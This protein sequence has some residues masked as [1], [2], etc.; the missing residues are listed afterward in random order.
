[1]QYKNTITNIKFEEL[2]NT[3]DYDATAK[4]LLLVRPWILPQA[5]A[6]IAEHWTPKKVGELYS[7]KATLQDISDPWSR[8]LWTMLT[9]VK[10]SLLV[11]K[12]ASLD[13]APYCGLVPLILAA[14]KKYHNIR[15]SEWN[16]SELKY[17]VDKH[18][19]DAMLCE[20]PKL[21]T[22]ELVQY[23]EIG[24]TLKTG[25]KA[26]QQKPPLSTWRLYNLQDT[27]L[28]NLPPLA[29][30]MLCQIWC[31]HPQLRNEYMVLDPQSWDHMP[32]PLL[33]DDVFYTTPK[34]VQKRNV[35]V[36]TPWD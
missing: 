12:Q 32:A 8:G 5:L 7:A 17:M 27:P 34:Q 6:H 11:P 26:G 33:V 19:L 31:A 35:V 1:M 23:R 13:G 21:T 36:E 30:T 20:V 22:D 29:Q 4:S 16:R 18:L 3:D 15:Y 14:Y 10:R 24:L 25:P 2:L 28:Q 9:S